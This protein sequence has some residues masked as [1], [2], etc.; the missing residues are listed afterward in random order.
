MPSFLATSIYSL[1]QTDAAPSC[2]TI[3]ISGPAGIIPP[4]GVARYTATVDTKEKKLDLKYFWTAAAGNI[5]S[6]QGRASI[7]VNQPELG[8]IVTVEITGLPNRC[9]DTASESYVIDLPPQPVKLAQFSVAMFAGDKLEMD[10]IAQAMS[11][12]P[13]NQLYVIRFQKRHA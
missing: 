12:H 4:N 11:D 9:P 13:N 3:S 10:R 5:V 1:G 8:N 2:P 7:E 6:G